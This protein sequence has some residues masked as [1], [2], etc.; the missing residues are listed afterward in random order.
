[1]QIGAPE[2]DA[3]TRTSSVAFLRRFTKPVARP[4]RFPKAGCDLCGSPLLTPHRHLVEPETRRILCS[5]DPCALR[6]QDVVEGK[7]RLVPRDVRALPGFVMTDA[8]WEDLALPIGLAYFFRHSQLQRTVA[9]YPSPAGATESL[10]SLEHWQNLVAANP[11]LASMEPDVEAL[12]VN[13]VR[14]ALDYFLVPI[15]RCY[16]LVGTIRKSWH[17]LSGGDEVWQEI[18]AFLAGLRAECSG[19]NSVTGAEL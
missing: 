12:L 18:S 14:Q 5:C 13:R 15:D 17:G 9:M 8:Q 11:V 19:T 3:A 7:F 16:Q 6:F 2:G 1:M 4:G 10:L